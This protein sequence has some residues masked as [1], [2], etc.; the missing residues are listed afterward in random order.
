MAELNTKYGLL[1]GITNYSIYKDTD[2]PQDIN[3]DTYNELKTP[4][5]ILVPRFE[6]KDG[7]R[8]ST[9]CLSFYQNGNMKSIDLNHQ[10]DISTSVGV[11]KAELITF[12][13]DEKL[14]RLFPRNG[15]L[16]GYW[17]QEDERELVE[18]IKIKITGEIYSTKVDSLTFYPNGALK[19]V[20]LLPNET[21]ELTTPAG[22]IA[23]GAGFSLYD[24]QTLKTLEPLAPTSVSTPI[25]K[26]LAFNAAAIGIHADN[27]SL[28]FAK[29]GSITELITSTNIIKITDIQNSTKTFMPYYQM[30]QLTAEGLETIPLR[31]TFSNESITFDHPTTINNDLVS[32]PRNSIITYEITEIPPMEQCNNSCTNCNI[33][34]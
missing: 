30:N 18:S 8:K 31:I 6:N 27:C 9:K 34:H 24:N 10:T 21:L 5:G 3:C 19:A 16:T 13:P 25:G 15:Q 17:T 33:C 20:S 4:L 26:L 23:V 1:K 7:R 32:I 2:A 14:H 29:D 28:H 11:L 12:Y 22:I